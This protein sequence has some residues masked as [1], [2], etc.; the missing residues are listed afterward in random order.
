MFGSLPLVLFCFYFLALAKTKVS[1]FISATMS[2]SLQISN[3]IRD[4]LQSC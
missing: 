1:A 3:N 4:T 2:E